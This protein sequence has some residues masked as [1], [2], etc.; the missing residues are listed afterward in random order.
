[1]EGENAAFPRARWEHALHLTLRS[2]CPGRPTARAQHWVST[3]SV[4]RWYKGSP[5][6]GRS[7]GGAELANVLANVICPAEL[8]GAA[9]W[10][11]GRS[12]LEAPEAAGAGE[13]AA[14]RVPR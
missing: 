2:L 9:V 7:L 10:E 5:Y 14:G 11:G 8:A 4:Y 3:Y 12:V 1:M 6:Q 13:G